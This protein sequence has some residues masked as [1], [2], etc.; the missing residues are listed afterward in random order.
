MH[1]GIHVQ[2]SFQP[3]FIVWLRPP[4]KFDSICQ[5]TAVA[6]VLVIAIKNSI[7]CMK[8]TRFHHIVSFLNCY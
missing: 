1:K 8:D 6:Y 4:N 3:S 5:F 2:P 7:L